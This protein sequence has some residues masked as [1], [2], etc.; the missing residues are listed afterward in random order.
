MAYKLSFC[1]DRQTLSSI[2]RYQALFLVYCIVN[3]SLLANPL[4][5]ESCE[6][7]LLYLFYHLKSLSSFL[8]IQIY[9]STQFLQRNHLKILYTYSNTY[10]NQVSTIFP[11]IAILQK[12]A[13]FISL[14]VEFIFY[15]EIFWQMVVIWI[16]IYQFILRVSPSIHHQQITKRIRL[17]CLISLST[18]VLQHLFHQ[19]FECC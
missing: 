17:A 12:S 9:R 4:A 7:D 14:Q 5:I 2:H 19:T 11:Q 1:F 6:E 15:G 8:S 3:I 18:H 16:D 13:S 10:V